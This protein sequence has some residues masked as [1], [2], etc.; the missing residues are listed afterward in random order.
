MNQNQSI[1]SQKIIN[2]NKNK[3]LNIK[4]SIIVKSINAQLI[5]KITN[6]TK[7]EI[8][9]HKNLKIKN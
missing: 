8:Q 4:I 6:K 7:I 1:K 5:L 2:K 9:N 3:K